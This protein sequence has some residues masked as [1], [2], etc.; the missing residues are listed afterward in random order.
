MERKHVNFGQALKA[1]D[2]HSALW[3]TRRLSQRLRGLSLSSVATCIIHLLIDAVPKLAMLMSLGVAKSS[4]LAGRRDPRSRG[5]CCTLGTSNPCQPF[6]L[7]M[8][9]PVAK[10]GSFLS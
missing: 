5:T 6:R 4:V 9:H 2:P 7:L 1:V 8:C 3:S 10:D